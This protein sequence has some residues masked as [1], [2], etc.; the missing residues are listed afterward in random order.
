M[1][2][3]SLP[4]A[5]E[6]PAKTMPAQGR[7]SANSL[8][9]SATEIPGAGVVWAK[10]AGAKLRMAA[11]TRAILRVIL[12]EFIEKSITAWDRVFTGDG[13]DGKPRAYGSAPGGL[14]YQGKARHV[15]CQEQHHQHPQDLRPNGAADPRQ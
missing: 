6:D 13:A 8:A 9:R 12:G 10:A 1:I 5:T 2:S 4:S 11:T 14:E 15:G 7:A 3:R